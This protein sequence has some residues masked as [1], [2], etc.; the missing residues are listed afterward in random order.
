MRRSEN[1]IL[2]ICLLCT[3]AS[4]KTV[5]ADPVVNYTQEAIET[6]AETVKETA[7]DLS[8]IIAEVEKAGAINQTQ[9]ESL[10]AKTNGLVTQTETLVKIVQAQTE[11]I[12]LMQKQN[13]TSLLEQY[14]KVSTLTAEVKAV[15]AERDRAISKLKPWKNT[16]IVLI[17]VFILLLVLTIAKIVIKYMV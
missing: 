17:I 8:G 2:L 16:A 5:P 7:L 14:D 6:N 15:T 11:N 3:L 10:K 1:Y 9:I 4:C 12:S 13:E